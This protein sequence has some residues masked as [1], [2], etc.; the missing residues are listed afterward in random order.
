[1]SSKAKLAWVA[2]EVTYDATSVEFVCNELANAGYV[3]KDIIFHSNQYKGLVIAFDPVL[4]MRNSASLELEKFLESAMGMPVGG[5][6][7]PR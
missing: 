2:K 5:S 4:A 1:M 6:N 7:D 3:I